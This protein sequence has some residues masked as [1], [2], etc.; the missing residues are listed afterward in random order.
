MSYSNNTDYTSTL[1]IIPPNQNIGT[2]TCKED[3]G[4][5]KTFVRPQDDRILINQRKVMNRPSVLAING[6]MMKTI[7]TGIVPLQILLSTHTKKGNILEG[8]SN[9]SLLSIG[10]LYN[11]D[12][13]AVFDKM[14]LHI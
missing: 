13:I 4:A 14:Y 9:S 1:T 7:E 3:I 12:C 6:T 2:V 10:Q 5:S 11:N 8:L